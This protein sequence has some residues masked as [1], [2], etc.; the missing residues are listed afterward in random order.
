[1]YGST[2]RHPHV[3]P[4]KLA[5]MALMATEP[6]NADAAGNVIELGAAVDAGCESKFWYEGTSPAA[7]VAAMKV[8]ASADP[9]G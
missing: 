8:D 6:P 9:F 3:R 1:M 5:L 4:D 7:T 2:C